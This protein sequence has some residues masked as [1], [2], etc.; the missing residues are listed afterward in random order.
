MAQN[1]AEVLQH[2]TI[3]YLVL[4]LSLP[5]KWWV[6]NRYGYVWIPWV[7]AAS[8]VVIIWPACAFGYRSTLRRFRAT[9]DVIPT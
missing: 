2:Q 6:S 1:G 5:I 9:T 8:F 7:G 4:A 3:G